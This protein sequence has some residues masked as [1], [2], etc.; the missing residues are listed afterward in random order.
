M[1]YLGCYADNTTTRALPNRIAFADRAISVERCQALAAQ[2]KYSVFALQGTSCFA[3]SS[4]SAAQVYGRW[5]DAA[6]SLTCLGNRLQRC[7]FANSTVTLSSLYQ[8]QYGY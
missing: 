7:G 4:L 5:A 8:L 1:A 2:G 6:C 3:G